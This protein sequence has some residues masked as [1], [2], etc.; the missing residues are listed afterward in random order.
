MSQEVDCIVVA[1]DNQAAVGSISNLTDHP[2]QRFSKMFRAHADRLLTDFPHLTIMVAWI[3]G[4]SGNQGNEVVDALA[5]MGAAAPSCVEGPSL[6]WLREHSRGK[7]QR[8]WRWE[9]PQRKRAMGPSM[10]MGNR[11]PS[12]K[13]AREM[14][15]IMDAKRRVGARAMQ[16]LTG[17]AFLGEFYNRMIP[18]EKIDCECGE[19]LQTRQHVLRDCPLFEAERFR[20]RK[21]IPSVDERKIVHS[22]A[23][24][25]ALLDFLSNTRAF[26]KPHRDVPPEPP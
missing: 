7:V 14:E 1:A 26:L 15:K 13:V 4:H 25:A 23:G 8:H 16:V 21:V 2:G 9:W 11:P 3:R 20:L 6:L 18:S 22:K 19:E 10:A 5:K 17:H 12:R 24:R